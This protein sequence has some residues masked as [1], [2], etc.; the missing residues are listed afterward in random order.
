MNRRPIKVVTYFRRGKIVRG[1]DRNI[2]HLNTSNSK[3]SKPV[4]TLESL[5]ETITDQ[6]FTIEGHT[7]DVANSTTLEN[8]DLRDMVIEEIDFSKITEIKNC[9]FNN[10]LLKNIDL[11]GIKFSNC[12]FQ[13]TKLLDVNLSN[14]TFE[15][16]TFDQFKFKYCLL[17]STRFEKCTFKSSTFRDSQL[18]DTQFDSCSF[19]TAEITGSEADQPSVIRTSFT[20]CEAND[21]LVEALDIEAI[22]FH[23]CSMDIAL[24]SIYVNGLEMEGCEVKKMSVF[25]SILRNSKISLSNFR[26]TSWIETEIS[27]AHFSKSTIQKGSFRAS[28]ILKSEF[29]RVNFPNFQMDGVVYQQFS[30]QE[31]KEKLGVT[32]R[33]FEFLVLS[34]VVEV[35]DNDTKKVVHGGFDPQK[36]HVPPW[37]KLKSVE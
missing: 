17:E 2:Q 25:G 31:A 11:S 8:L 19:K 4:G 15:E 33:Q 30:F 26:E 18:T 6:A 13:E 36:H 5:L 28:S 32:D 1:H 29:D 34:G 9:S 22:K 27:R 12:R 23:K 16:C 37:S 10:T 20:D 14:S 35:R 21:L 7:I 24:S 3:I